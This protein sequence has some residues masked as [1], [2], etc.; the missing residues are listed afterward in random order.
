MV[1]LNFQPFF[2][3]LIS[4]MR[5]FQIWDFEGSIC[6]VSLYILRDDESTKC[7]TSVY[8]TRYNAIGISRLIELMQEAGFT[9]VR[10]L[11]DCSIGP[12]IVGKK[13][14]MEKSK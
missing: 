12:A 11:E 4:F 8:R 3:P 7:R 1:T 5:L 6:D 13:N 10:R 9:S 2:I 14:S